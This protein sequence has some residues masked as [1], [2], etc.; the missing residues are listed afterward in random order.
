M[1]T[2]AANIVH[3]CTHRGMPKGCHVLS[4]YTSSDLYQVVQNMGTEHFID[5]CEQLPF[6]Y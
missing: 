5:E 2:K 1:T 3:A 4:I 6:V